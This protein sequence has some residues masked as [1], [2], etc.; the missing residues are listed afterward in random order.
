MNEKG[1]KKREKRIKNYTRTQVRAVT[2]YEGEK[3]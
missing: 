2:A 3:E 1:N